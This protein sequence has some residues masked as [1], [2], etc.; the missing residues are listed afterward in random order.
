[1]RWLFFDI[2]NAPFTEDKSYRMGY[3]MPEPYSL[4]F[5]ASFPI[6]SYRMLNTC[7]P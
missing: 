1:M 5:A 3:T 7:C 2:S 4:K 6:K